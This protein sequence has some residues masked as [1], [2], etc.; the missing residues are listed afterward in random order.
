MLFYPGAH[1]TVN[2]FSEAV[3]G[4][5][6]GLVCWRRRPRYGA[7]FS[8]VQSRITCKCPESLF[9]AMPKPARETRVLPNMRVHTPGR[10]AGVG[11]GLGVRRGLA[12]GVGR[13]VAVGVAVAVGLEVGVGVAVGE[14]VGLPADTMKTYTLL[15]AAK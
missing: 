8:R 13:A 6:G 10:G 3:L 9:R 7:L 1:T 15:S 4:S 2:V 5:A 14:G 11:R 12:V